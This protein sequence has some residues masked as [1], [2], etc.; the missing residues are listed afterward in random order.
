[1][2]SNL[3]SNVRAVPKVTFQPSDVGG[4]FRLDS[5][6]FKTVSDFNGYWRMD[7]GGKELHKLQSSHPDWKKMKYKCDGGIRFMLLDSSISHF[8][9]VKWTTMAQ[10]QEQR[11]WNGEEVSVMKGSGKKTELKL[12]VKI[13][14]NTI[15]AQSK[16]A[17]PG[18]GCIRE[19]YSLSPDRLKL[20]IAVTLEQRYTGFRTHPLTTSMVH[21]VSF[22]RI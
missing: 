21:N 17:S 16:L 15:E 22:S 13:N 20:T 4:G 3:G 12:S 2:G 9:I 8:R 19:V 1:M 6:N 14:A 18:V 11:P 10:H 7:T 5:W